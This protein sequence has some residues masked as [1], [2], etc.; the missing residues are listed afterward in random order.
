MHAPRPDWIVLERHP[1]SRRRQESEAS[2][3]LT[4][5]FHPHLLEVGD[6]HLRLLKQQVQE[7]KVRIISDGVIEMVGFDKPPQQNK[8]FL[9]LPWCTLDIDGDQLGQLYQRTR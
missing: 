1:R 6:Q 8:T 9:S 5:S 2:K 7:G 3:T 4:H